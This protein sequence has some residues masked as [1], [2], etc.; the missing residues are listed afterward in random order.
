[1]ISRTSGHSS[2]SIELSLKYL[3]FEFVVGAVSSYQSAATV[4]FEPGSGVLESSTS[5]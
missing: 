1:M 2:S 3:V 4:T 5:T